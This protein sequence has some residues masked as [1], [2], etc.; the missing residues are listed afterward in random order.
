MVDM[1]KPPGGLRSYRTLFQTPGTKGFSGAGFLARMPAS[2]LGIGIVLLVHHETGSYAIASTVS[3]SAALVQACSAPFLARLVDR[4]GQAQVA[5]PAVLVSASGL[6][7]L[8]LSINTHAP[9][10]TLY[11]CA[12]VAGLAMPNIGSMVRARWAALHS[13]SP[14]L[15]TAYSFESVVD[16]VV[17]VI[18]PVV[19]TFLTTGAVPLA[20]L[21]TAL[22]CLLIGTIALCLQ[23]GTQPTPTP[24]SRHD[25]PGAFRLKGVQTVMAVFLGIGCLF[26]SVEVITVAYAGE[27]GHQ[28]L[29]GLLLA[30]YAGGSLIAGL[31]FGGVHWAGT[32]QR[33]FPYLLGLMA[34]TAALLPLAVNLWLLALLLF[35]AGFSISPSLITAITLIELLVPPARLTEG[36]ATATTG[37]A[38]GLTLGSGLA[39]PLIDDF[40]A[41][42]AYLLSAAGA[43]WALLAAVL[44]RRHLL[45]PPGARPGAPPDEQPIAQPHAEP[46]PI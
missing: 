44:L 35:L 26:G 29:A 13:G 27:R 46:E 5:L 2:M 34:V 39:G 6:G 17:F 37:I 19:V 15:H 42:G 12:I 4:R 28:G 9:T 30:G 20:G 43:S 1:S 14:Q 7:G 31:V 10:W 22:L 24:P 3:S 41:R 18:G 23:R 38:L 40:G 33:R 21:G 32:P 8:L 25:G 11:L 45:T 36:L 16:E